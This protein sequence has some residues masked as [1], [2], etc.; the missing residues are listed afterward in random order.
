LTGLELRTL[1]RVYFG[2]VALVAITGVVAA[3][4][5]ADHAAGWQHI[6]F[7]HLDPTAGEIAS[8]FGHNLRVLA[9]AVGASV[10]VNAPW[11]T[12]GADRPRLT[13]GWRALRLLCDVA[14]GAAVAR[15]LITVGLDLGAFRGRMLLAVLPHG[16]LELLAFSFGLTLYVEARRGPVAPNVWLS[17]CA[18]AVPVLAVAAT[19]EV[20]VVL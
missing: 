11:L 15:N 6:P 18:A 2:S 20:L 10:A 4:V 8:V 13:R 12:A 3:F 7:P 9:A 19:V 5:F 16:P 1:A 14:L 17:F